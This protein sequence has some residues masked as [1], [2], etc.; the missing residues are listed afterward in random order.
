MTS[1]KTN[2]QVSEHHPEH[3]LQGNVQCDPQQAH[4]MQQ[5]STI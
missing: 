4:D 1:L 5:T 3:Q 2:L